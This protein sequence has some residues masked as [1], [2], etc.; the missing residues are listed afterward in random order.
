MGHEWA[1]RLLQQPSDKARRYLLGNLN[2][3][4]RET[5]QVPYQQM[6]KLDR[7]ALSRLQGLSER[8]LKAYDE[9]NFHLVYHNLHN[10]C[11]LD[12]SSFY[13]DI[14][15]DRLYTSSKTS[16][17]RR[18][19]QSAMNEIL[20][21]LVRLMA[22]VLSFTADE[23]WQYMDGKERPLSVH[24]DCFRPI[25]DTYRDPEL[26]NV[27]E[28]IIAVRKEVTRIL[29]IARKE[30][31]IG[32]SLDASVQLGVPNKLYELLNG[33]RDHLKFIFIVSS[34][35]LADTDQ[36]DGGYES[37]TVPGLKVAVSPSTEPKCERCWVHD[38]SIGED[39]N[40]PTICKRCRDVLQEIMP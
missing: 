10:F 34:V 14:I 31:H 36:M 3:F 23:I 18:S 30:K 15:K 7:W 37:E 40:H 24:A 11:V 35:A 25:N 33:Y 29:E 20:E 5:D 17:A 16:L 4:D 12:L 39:S 19:A 22:P 38:P 2:D 8:V 6:E 32:H 13:L 28:Q 9:F 1:W 27:W 26:E 21:V